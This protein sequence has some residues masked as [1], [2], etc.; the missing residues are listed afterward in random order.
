MTLTKIDDRGLKTPIDLLDNEK[1]RLGTG[2]DLEIF[3]DGGGSII[4]DVGTGDLRIG[5]DGDLLVMNAALSET[6]A[7]FS[8]NGAVELYHDN[9]K[10]LETASGGVAITGNVTVT[11]TIP[12]IDLVDTNAND[13]FQIRVNAGNFAIN[14]TTNSIN[15]FLIDSSGTVDISGNLDVGAGLDVTGN[16]GINVT[17]PDSPLEVGGTGPSLATIHHTDGGTNDEARLM[18]G[19]LSSN[20]PDQRG[21]GI[22]ARNKGAGHA[23]E[24]QTSSTHSAGPSTKVIVTAGGQL[25]VPNDSVGLQLGAGQDL[26]IFHNGTNSIIENVTGALVIKP[27]GLMRIQDRTTDE[28]RAD[29]NDNGS[30]DLYYNGSKKFE[31]TS[32]GTKITGVIEIDRGSA[33]DEALVINTTGTNG[34]SRI[35]FKESGTSKGELAYSHGNDQVE[36]VAK[37]GNGAAIIV[38]VNQTALQINSSGHVRKPLNPIFH[39]FGGPANVAT[40]TDIVFGQ[41]RFDVGGGYNTSNG[42]Y[43][44]PVTGYYHFYGQVYRQTTS[45][46]S[47]WGFY[48][49]GSQKSEARLQTNYNQA[50]GTGQGY[51]T[52]QSSIYWYCSAGDT[53]KMRVGAAGAIHCNNTLSYFCGNLVG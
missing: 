41:E 42:V 9:S 8:S 19:A 15:R 23:L 27:D 46:D 20:P 17:S 47:W 36:L 4:K 52:L 44:V 49:N 1:I 39:A 33:I 32:N 34:A 37:T 11:S 31:T 24:I 51:A 30:V 50:S 53:V 40:N 14:D 43:T 35:T 6:K 7:K 13:D 26:Q 25:Q 10:K 3:H 2:N 38:N 21:A 16:L 45:A 18:L 22:S 12:T 29:F 48:I 5:G 28:F